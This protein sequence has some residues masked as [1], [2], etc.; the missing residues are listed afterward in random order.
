MRDARQPSNGSGTTARTR[1][2]DLSALDALRE[3]C[4]AVRDPRILPH[5][6]VRVLGANLCESANDPTL[7]CPLG[8]LSVA[9]G[10]VNR[11]SLSLL[12]DQLGAKVDAQAAS[13]CLQPGLGVASPYPG[14]VL[15]RCTVL[16]ERLW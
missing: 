4:S 10:P 5:N 3:A 12:I 6:S 16:S 1:L 11:S 9:A 15:A 8:V 14:L 2:T 7:A 13:R